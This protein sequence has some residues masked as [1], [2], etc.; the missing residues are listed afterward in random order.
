MDLMRFAESYGH[1]FDFPIEHAFEYRDYLIRAFNADV[2][3]DDFI[4]EHIAGDLVKRPR[5]HP[6]ED[7]NESIIGTGFWFLSEA[8]HA[9]LDVRSWLHRQSN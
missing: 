5:R 9:P 2:P 3:Y 7:F 1:E 6:G 8:K 4:V